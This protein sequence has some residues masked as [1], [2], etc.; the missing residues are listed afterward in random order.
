MAQQS[1]IWNRSEIVAALHSATVFGEDFA[2]TGVSIDTRTLQEGDIFV[3]LTGDHSNGHDYVRIAQ[4]RGAAALIISEPDRAQTVTI[5]CILVE[6]CEQSLRDLASFRRKQTRASVIAITGSVGKTSTKE[7]LRF[8]LQEFGKTYATDGNYN[9]HIGVPLCMARMSKDCDY[10][11]FEIGTSNPGE[12]SPLSQLVQPDLAI[13]TAV[14]AAHLQNFENIAAIAREKLSIID[15]LKESGILFF[16]GITC[17]NSYQ[18]C[19]RVSVNYMRQY[20]ALDE[21][22]QNQANLNLVFDGFDLIL[23]KLQTVL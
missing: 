1:V 11:I 12:I 20:S 22:N 19:G 13:I 14:G 4:D 15:G 16:N 23:Q 8:V 9:N 18:N 7:A 5:P 6:N 21:E 17:P 3:A 10:A 2:G